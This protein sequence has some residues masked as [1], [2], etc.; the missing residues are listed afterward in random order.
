M[1]GTVLGA[2]DVTMNATDVHVTCNLLHKTVN[3]QVDHETALCNVSDNDKYY[4]QK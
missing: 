1:S 4:G 2:G 3:K